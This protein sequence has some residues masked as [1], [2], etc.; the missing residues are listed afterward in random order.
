MRNALTTVRP[1]MPES[2]TPI[3]LIASAGPPVV[4]ALFTGADRDRGWM[5]MLLFRRRVGPE[6]LGNRTAVRRQVHLRHGEAG[7]GRLVI[8]RGVVI[9]DAESNGV[10]E[11]LAIITCRDPRSFV[12]MANKTAL[13][14]HRRDLHVAQHM[15]TRVFNPAVKGAQPRQNSRVDRCGQRN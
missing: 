9:L 6:R 5:V 3:G 15:K 13:D 10:A 4:G 1:P 8:Y 14:E 11:A 7:S 12:G 2:K